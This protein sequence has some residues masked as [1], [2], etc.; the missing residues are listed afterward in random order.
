MDLH[1]YKKDFVVIT[2]IFLIVVSIF[3]VILFQKNPVGHIVRIA[4]VGDS[5]TKGSNYPEYLWMLVGPD[6]KVGNF[7]VGSATVSIQS[8]KPY[9]NQSEFV[10]AKNF[11]P[12]VV[13]I[14]LGTNDAYPSNQQTRTKFVEDYIT[15]VREFQRLDSAPKIVLVEPP[16]VLRNGT[17]INTQFFTN[18]ILPAIKEVASMLNLQVIDLYTPL[19]DFP[20]YFSFDGVHPS[21]RGSQAIA[22]IIHNTITQ[23]E[24]Q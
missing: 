16:P 3:G 1:R 14:M 4:C 24:K 19:S 11:G 15:L 10:E 9:I 22:E 8:N 5:L 17:G 7:G 18:N 2:A 23:I 13:V 6:Y 20:Q 21:E 12:D